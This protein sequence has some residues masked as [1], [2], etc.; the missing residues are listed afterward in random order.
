MQ[1]FITLV[2]KFVGQ[3]EN[4]IRV[5]KEIIYCNMKKLESLN[6]LKFK[7]NVIT[8]LSSVNGGHIFWRFTNE[9]T[10]TD[11]WNGGDTDISTYSCDSAKDGHITGYTT[12]TTTTK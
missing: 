7:E 3:A 5:G 6:N 2:S 9:I 12:T 11:Y 8:D 4:Q 10:V 1:K